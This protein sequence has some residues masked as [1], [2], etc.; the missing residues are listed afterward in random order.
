MDELHCNRLACRKL[1]TEK[2]VVTTC[3]HIFCIECANGIF[4][5]PTLVC[6]ACETTLDQPDDVVICSLHPTNDYKTSILSGLSPTIILE[7]CSRAMSFWQY[8]IHQESSFQ[9][10]V[11]RNA[12]ERNAQMQK[13]L[14]NVVREANSELSLLNTKVAALERDLEVERRKN[15]DLMDAAKDKDAEYQKLKGQLDKMKRKALLGST[16]LSA[17]AQNADASEK[18]VYQSN[19]AGVMLPSTTAAADGTGLHGTMNTNSSR[20][21]AGLHQLGVSGM[22]AGA[23]NQGNMGEVV[24]GMDANKARVDVNQSSFRNTGTASIL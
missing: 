18:H 23:S 3:S 13:Q 12:N 20:L 17:A 10:A 21:R 14:E 19:H 24:N 8:Q 2:A 9:Q 6:A 1:L 16:S 4:S 11:L 7:I 15:R 5:T 22:H